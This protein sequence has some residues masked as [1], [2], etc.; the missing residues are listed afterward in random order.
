MQEEKERK[1]HLNQLQLKKTL[2][3]RVFLIYP[4]HLRVAKRKKH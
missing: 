4:F 2:K 1:K 3:E